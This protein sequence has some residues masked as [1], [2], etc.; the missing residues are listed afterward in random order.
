[1][2]NLDISGLSSFN[3]DVNSWHDPSIWHEYNMKLACLGL[4]Q[5]EFGSLTGQLV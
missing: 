5:N 4:Y 1:M 2:L 3:K